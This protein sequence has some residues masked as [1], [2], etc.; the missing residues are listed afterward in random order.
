MA[1][2]RGKNEV[3]PRKMCGHADRRCLLPRTQMDGAP[4]FL[5]GIEIG[6]GAF[7]GS[8]SQLVAPV[9]VGDGAYVAAGSTITQPVPP[10]ALG[11]SRTPQ[12]NKDGW[13]S[14]RRSGAS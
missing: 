6:E 9:S 2:M 7:I 13:V 1:A 14:K 11:I 12:T 4:H 5:F 10:G 8:D 3:V